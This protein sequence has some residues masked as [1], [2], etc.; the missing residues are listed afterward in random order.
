MAHALQEEQR[1]ARP[2]LW[3]LLRDAGVNWHDDD[4]MRMSSSLAYY[5]LLSLAPLLLLAVSIAGLFLGDEAARGHIARSLASRFGEQAGV[6][7][8]AAIR[9]ADEPAENI[10]GAVTGILVLLVGASGVLGEL[11]SAMNA[12]WQVE[13]RPGRGLRGMLRDR[14]VCYTMVGS[15]T[16]MLVGLLLAAALLTL[17]DKHVGKLPGGLRLWQTVDVVLSLVAI[18][19]LFAVTFKTVPDVKLTFRDV[20]PGA[21]LTGLMFVLGELAL[22]YYFALSS[23]PNPYG[24]AGASIVLVTWA[25]YTGQILF[26]GVEFTKVRAAARGIEIRPRPHAIRK[27]VPG[28]SRL[29]DGERAAQ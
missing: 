15:V 3:Q 20:W 7:I 11:Q 1:R 4:A 25:Y 22:G 17:L 5:T 13:P 19:L 8:E 12:I 2:R 29:G 26:F 16:L 21:L 23:S 6:A 27:R 10:L 9:S 14:V 24:A 18:V 28:G